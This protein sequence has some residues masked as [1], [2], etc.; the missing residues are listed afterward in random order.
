MN[1]KEIEVLEDLKNLLN[2]YEIVMSINDGELI[3]QKT[4]FDDYQIYLEFYTYIDIYKI[5]GLLE[6]EKENQDNERS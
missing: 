2:K 4:S 3:I 6:I 5:D 1:K